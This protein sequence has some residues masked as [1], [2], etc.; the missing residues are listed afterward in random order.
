MTASLRT[1]D[2]AVTEVELKL[3]IPEASAGEVAAWLRSRGARSGRLRARYFDSINRDLA[4]AKM[5][6]RLR[7][8]RGRWVQTL[9]AATAGPMTRFEHE[10]AVQRG[11]PDAPPPLAP[12]LHEATE[13]RPLLARA[14]E[15]AGPEGLAAQ[16]ETDIRRTS[17]LYRSR[18][19][20]VEISLDIGSISAPGCDALPVCE[21]EIELA[22]G[23]PLAV[24]DVARQ[25]VRRFSAWIDPATKAERGHGLAAR[26]SR[27]AAVRAGP[28]HLD[29]TA[30]IAE[31][32]RAVLRECRR[33]MLPNLAALASEHD[34]QPEHVH[35]ARVALRRLRSAIRLFQY[36]PLL[37]LDAKAQALS[38]ALGECRKRDVLLESVAPQLSKAGAPTTE[39]AVL[40][41]TADARGITR[42]RDSQAL[43]LELIE[44]ELELDI[45]PPNTT[46]AA[47][48]QLIARLTD[49][50]RK[51]RRDA[52][53]FEA[54][55]DERRHQLRRRMKRLRYGIEFCRSLCSDKRYRRM[56]RSLSEAQETLGRYND[57]VEALAGYRTQ[58]GQ[59]PRAW[60]AVG[61]LTAEIQAQLLRCQAAL[62][63]LRRCD[64]PWRVHH[65]SPP[66]GEPPK[67]AAK[68]PH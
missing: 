22:T 26:Q 30:G 41:Q 48:P 33:Q 13:V 31:C 51:V 20:Q 44:R 38:R 60:F 55:D 59:D 15:L 45:A 14:L 67:H 65:H 3:H 61:W 9:K 18:R 68:P 16:F 10:V 24:T 23:S 62:A 53:Q 1:D 2:K 4:K 46:E 36:A 39:L 54:L 21:I 47:A 34:H 63:A 7:Y 11:Q 37:G 57:L 25:V 42:R 40:S 52:R 5:A 12:S 49:W 8:E 66:G 27:G 17:T 28:V 56:L 32:A 29:P 19:G 6:L 35:Q 58:A 64:T 50:H 43:L